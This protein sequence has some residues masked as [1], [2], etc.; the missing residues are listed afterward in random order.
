M[1]PAQGE[2]PN[3]GIPFVDPSTVDGES[4][5]IAPYDL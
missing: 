4:A 3:D 2:Q 1:N 5:H